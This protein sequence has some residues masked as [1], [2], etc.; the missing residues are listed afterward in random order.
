MSYLNA[1]QMKERII[2]KHLLIDPY[3]EIFQ[4][5]NL[6]YCHLGN[7]FI[8]PKRLDVPFDPMN[9]QENEKNFVK[10]YITEPIVIESNQFFLAETFEFFA[11]DDITII[12]L[13]NS[14]SLAR[15][16]ISH[17]AIGMINPG[18]GKYNPVRLTLELVNHAPYPIILHPTCIEKETRQVIHWGT[19]VLKIGVQVIAEKVSQSYSD[20]SEAIYHEDQEVSSSKMHQRFLKAN[21]FIIPT[22]SVVLK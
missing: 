8:F 14:S 13:F 12:R 19:E 18:C 20:W 7:S 10:K 22:E 21:N 2:E 11:T 5:P 1:R 3:C 4:G 6:Y 15:A 9:P 17:C 16:G